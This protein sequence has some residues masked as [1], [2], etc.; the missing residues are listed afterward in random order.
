MS[1]HCEDCCDK[2]NARTKKSRDRKKAK[3]VGQD[4]QDKIQDKIDSWFRHLATQLKD[5]M[6]DLKLIKEKLGIRRENA[7]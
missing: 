7:N 2:A 1:I 4:R 3:Q 6:S 5:V